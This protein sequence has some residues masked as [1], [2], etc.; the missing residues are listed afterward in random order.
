MWGGGQRGQ[1]LAVGGLPE[2]HLRHAA[3]ADEITNL[4]AEAD[5]RSE[6]MMG[7]VLGFTFHIHYL[8]SSSQQTC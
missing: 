8:I 4:E 6:T 2:R 3:L 7:A 1:C 5:E